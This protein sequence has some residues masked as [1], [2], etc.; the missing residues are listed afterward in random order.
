M[1]ALYVG[2]SD[3][4]YLQILGTNREFVPV[5]LDVYFQSNDP[6]FATNVSVKAAL[7]IGVTT[8]GEAFRVAVLYSI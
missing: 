7:V 4:A 1:L 5:K 8:A 3:K 6:L 2:L